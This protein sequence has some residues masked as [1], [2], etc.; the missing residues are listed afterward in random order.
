M[1]LQTIIA[2]IIAFILGKFSDK[3]MPF[4]KKSAPY[5]KE[6]GELLTE[7]AKA[8]EDGNLTKDEILAIMKEAKD[9]FELLTI[10]KELKNAN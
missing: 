2:F 1:D 9:V 5:S 6:I 7:F 8:A 10:A 4:L 3:V